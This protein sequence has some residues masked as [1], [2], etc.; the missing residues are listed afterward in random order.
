MMADVIGSLG[1]DL[2]RLAMIIV[3]AVLGYG[4]GRYLW[5]TRHVAVAPFPII[6][7]VAFVG[8]LSSRLFAA[9]D[10]TDVWQNVFFP[11]AVSFGAGFSVT[12]ARPP[13]QS[14][15]WQLWRN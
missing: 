5:A 1:P 11:V 6:A 12:N 7:A 3:G 2:L 4:A 8:L 14:R 9:A 10:L 13:L 15:W